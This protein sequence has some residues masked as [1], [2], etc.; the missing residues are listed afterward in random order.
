MSPTITTRRS[1]LREAEQQVAALSE[2]NAGL[3]GTVQLLEESV[4]ELQLAMEDVG[5]T[6]MLAAAEQ[7]FTRDGLVRITAGCR[8]FAVKNPLIVRGLQLRQ[9]YV[10]GQGVEISARANGKNREN[11]REQDVQAVVRAFLDDAGNRQALTDASAQIRNER[12]LG[13]DGNLFFALWTKPST[14]WVQVR[15]L[16]W[17]E[18][19][20]VIRNPQ[21]A[22]EPWF[23]KRVWHEETVDYTTGL[24]KTETQTAYYP[25]LGYRPTGRNRPR[26]I[27]GHKVHW[28]APVRHVKVND[29]QGWKFGIGDA[30]AALD[31]A[32]AYKE[33]LEAWATLVK[34][35]SRFAYRMTAKGSQRAQAKTRLAAAPPRDPH[36]GNPQEAGATAILPPDMLLEAV[37]KTGATIDSESG[38]PLAAMVA[39]A[40]GVP[41]TM[42]LGD[43][44][45]TGA[46]ATAE[47]LDQPTELVM[48][49]RQ[50]V[51]TEVLRD[52]VGY[53]IAE[54]VRATKGQ[55]TGRIEVDPVTGREVVTLD[56]DTAATV[57][58]TWPDLDD[59]DPK[60]LVEAIKLASDTG[61]VPPETIL[62]LL[63]TALGARDVD[64]I[65]DR[66]IGD[67]GEFQ[68]PTTPG[69][70]GQAVDAAR[71]GGDP[72]TV[73]AGRMTPTDPDP[74]TGD[75]E[76]AP[77]REDS[78]SG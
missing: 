67:D 18:I 29:Q 30:Y 59:V 32:R 9:A 39:A 78:E 57:E 25:A 53:V 36:T 50:Q 51:W 54:A 19:Q 22:S 47:T 71:S 52:I 28:D 33:F 65:V 35:L 73:G 26:T 4:A 7:E 49:Q 41:V 20:D 14:G 58:I 15:T 24:P 68:W 56:G 70:G 11:S 1:R 72:A 61:T 27:G 6:R 40:L 77:T 42:L 5:W 8:L 62:R 31:W 64:E 38:R 60:A 34:A 48:Q 10:F 69:L 74:P 17:D 23:Y 2:Q 76:T 43:P 16:P 46:R 21:D 45:V 44:G 75:L 13:T 12:A 63:L 37:P 3:V 55:L 66:L